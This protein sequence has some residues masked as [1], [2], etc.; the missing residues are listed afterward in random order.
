VIERKVDAPPV[1]NG[2]FADQPPYNEIKEMHRRD[3]FV[4]MFQYA[5]LQQGNPRQ[6]DPTG[7]YNC[8]DCNKYLPNNCL[9]VTGPISGKHGS[10]RH[11]ENKDAGDSELKFAEKLSKEDA[12]YGETT[13]VGFGCKRCE[14]KSVAIKPD[15]KGRTGWCGQGAMHVDMNGCCFRNDGPGVTSFEENKPKKDE[16]KQPSTKLSSLLNY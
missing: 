1:S 10:C 16:P 4:A 5:D 8:D 12:G 3:S 2:L 11:W 9:Q 15:S 13:A 6:Y 7:G 14:Y